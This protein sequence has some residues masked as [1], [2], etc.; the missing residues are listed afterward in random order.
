MQHIMHTHYKKCL[1]CNIF[2]CRIIN[3]YQSTQI[4]QQASTYCCR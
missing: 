4:T 3:S 2:I 1:F